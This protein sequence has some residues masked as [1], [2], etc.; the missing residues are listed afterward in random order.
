[1]T[2]IQPEYFIE[3]WTDGRTSNQEDGKTNE[4]DVLIEPIDRLEDALNETI[5]AKMYTSAVFLIKR[6]NNDRNNI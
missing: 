1:M 2:R 5:M 4:F 3:V 6:K